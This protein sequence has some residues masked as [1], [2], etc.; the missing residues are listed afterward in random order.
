MFK[1]L[2]M[3]I[4]FTAIYSAIT[5]LGAHAEG[6]I[7]QPLSK[8]AMAVIHYTQNGQRIIHSPAVLLDKQTIN[9][10]PVMTVFANQRVFKI[11]S[12]CYEVSSLFSKKG[13]FYGSCGQ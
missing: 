3:G 12:G 9:G 6:P 7:P 11:A 2:V 4:I 8:E 5:S 10:F 13:N 1:A